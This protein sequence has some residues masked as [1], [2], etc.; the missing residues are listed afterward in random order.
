MTKD[1]HN[2]ITKCERCIKFK[3]KTDLRTPLVN[4][5]T[6]QPLE[7]VCIDFLTL[8]AAKG[9]YENIL[10]I[11]DHYTKYAQEIPTKNQL[12][13]TTAKALYDNF[14][15]H[16]GL[17]SK[18]HSDQGR[19]F[20]SEVISS[21]CKILNIKKSRTTAYHPQG[22]GLVERFNRTLISM[23]GTLKP[24]EK[25]D[26]KKYL[27]S[28]VFAYNCMRHDTTGYSPYYLMFNRQPRLPID[29]ILGVDIPPEN[30]P[31][32]TY[33]S[34]MKERMQCTYN[35]ANK[36]IDSAQKQQKK[37]HDKKVRSSTL[38]E[39][40]RVLLKKV[41]FSGKHKLC[42]KWQDEVYIV[43][44]QP[45]Q[46]IPVFEIQQESNKRK[47]K[48]V[49]RNKLLP[50]GELPITENQNKEVDKQ[51]YSR[52]EEK[53][54]ETAETIEREE[55]T[56]SDSDDDIEETNNAIPQI[57]SPLRKS[58]RQR[59]QTKK[60]SYQQ[61]ETKRKKRKPTGMR[62]NTKFNDVVSILKHSMT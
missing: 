21:L 51:S 61:T 5:Q 28:L 25:L 13:T 58:N 17:P 30:K 54:S 2:H 18:L 32:P 4:I 42:D 38:A 59:K 40:D 22:N 26:W 19:N 16:Y 23:L 43:K 48:T 29:I 7:L 24:T 45:N 35:I 55:N 44:Q 47:K 10:V 53:K 46:D 6:S 39:G 20:E 34:E 1:I 31:Y 49:H 57:Q 56:N 33:V 52:I 41:V 14:F 12:A 15:V 3:T 62:R 36:N 37:Q 50:I 9:G 27:P 11:S 60:F 8:E